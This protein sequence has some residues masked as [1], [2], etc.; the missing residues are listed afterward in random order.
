MKRKKQSAQLFVLLIAI[1][2]ISVASHILGTPAYTGAVVQID[3]LDDALGNID[4]LQEEYN[5]QAETIPT[6]FISLFGNEVIKFTIQ[7]NDDSEIILGI[8]T[9]DGKITT[10]DESNEEITEEEYTMS[11][12]LTEETFDTILHAENQRAAARAA[13]E[14][15][16]ITYEAVTF[17]AK[18]KTTVA[19]IALTIYSWFS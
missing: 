5:T 4:E 1:I 19:E 17:K 7:R 3:S 12:Q 2:L 11:V 16:A 13:F 18:V 10:I 9:T 6:F 15:G 14:S 8:K